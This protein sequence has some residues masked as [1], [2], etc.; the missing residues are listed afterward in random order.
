MMRWSQITHLIYLNIKLS[1]C[2]SGAG[3]LK[4]TGIAR[5]FGVGYAHHYPLDSHYAGMYLLKTVNT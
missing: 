1:L 4:R 3:A 2:F 5:D